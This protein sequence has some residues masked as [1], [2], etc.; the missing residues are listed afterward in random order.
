MVYD[1]VPSEDVGTV[2]AKLLLVGLIVAVCVTPLTVTV[3]L[4]GGMSE[5]AEMAPVICVLDVPAITVGGVTR[6]KY[7]WALLTTCVSVLLLLRK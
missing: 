6:L 2:T 5:P 3:T 7:G 1:P 4:P